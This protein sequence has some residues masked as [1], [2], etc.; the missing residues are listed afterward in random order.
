[1]SE[2]G[3][4]KLARIAARINIVTALFFLWLPA[5]GFPKK[6]VISAAVDATVNVV[7][8]MF[9]YMIMRVFSVEQK[10]AIETKDD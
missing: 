3:M 10:T 6:P 5:A 4:H 8:L 7:M 1:M 9:S 2:A